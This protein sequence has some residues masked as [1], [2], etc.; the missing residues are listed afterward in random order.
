MTNALG[1]VRQ[2]FHT[3]LIFQQSSNMTVWVQ[4][5]HWPELFSGSSKAVRVTL[6]TYAMRPFS[7]YPFILPV[8]HLPPHR[9]T[10]LS[11]SCIGGSELRASNQSVPKCLIR[12]RYHVLLDSSASKP[13]QSC[14]LSLSLN[15]T[16]RGR[17]LHL[18]PWHRQGSVCWVELCRLLSTPWSKAVYQLMHPFSSSPSLLSPSTPFLSCSLPLTS[19]PWIL[20]QQS[21]TAHLPPGRELVLPQPP[22]LFTFILS[23]G[24]VHISSHVSFGLSTQIN[25]KKRIQEV[26][27]PHI[28]LPILLSL[29]PGSIYLALTSR[30]PFDSKCSLTAL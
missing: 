15:G 26:P 17:V 30:S 4:L 23:R 13:A 5:G 10:Q 25:G 19:S 21:S 16:V 18:C 11:S 28:C 20:L 1:Y 6:T 22:F 24:M 9:R 8:H 7:I 3:Q 29:V 14:N 27:S 12:T 2:I